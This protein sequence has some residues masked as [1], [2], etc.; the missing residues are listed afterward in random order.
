MKTPVKLAFATVL[1]SVVLTAGALA[2]DLKVV[3]LPNNHGVVTLVYRQRDDAQPTVGVYAGGAGV[4]Q[5][6]GAADLHLCFRD[7]GHGVFQPQYVAR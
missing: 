7:N 3:A 6:A 2:D 5:N 1:A 4:G